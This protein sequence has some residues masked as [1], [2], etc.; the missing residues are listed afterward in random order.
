MSNIIGKLC[1]IPV[2][3]AGIV[4]LAA[5]R[6][7]AEQFRDAE[8]HFTID[9]P[10][11]WEVIPKDS[12]AAANA[13]GPDWLRASAVT[14]S[15]GLQRQSDQR[16]GSPM[17][18]IQFEPVD[19]RG[20]SIEDV[21]RKWATDFRNNVKQANEKF[22]TSGRRVTQ[23]TP[24]VFNRATSRFVM[25]SRMDDGQLSVVSYGIGA[26]GRHGLVLMHCYA[27]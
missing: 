3:A 7:R 13:A 11:G 12:I 20:K 24:L 5:H 22:V 9:V 23:E 4:L 8:R 26:A 25:Q 16:P 27:R 17:I 19:L 1:S 6:G 18:L 21:E 14:Y 10:A 15:G 2:L